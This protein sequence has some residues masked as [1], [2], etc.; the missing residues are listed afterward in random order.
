MPYVFFYFGGVQLHYN[1]LLV[2][3]VQ[4]NESAMYTYIPSVWKSFM[5]YW[6]ASGTGRYLG[7]FP[8]LQ[9]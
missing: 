6:D 3:T 5:S 9:S 4:Q 8:E 7:E 1:V 2:S